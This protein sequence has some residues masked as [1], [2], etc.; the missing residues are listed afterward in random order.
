MI[1]RP[2]KYFQPNTCIDCG[3][4]ISRYS[5]RCQKCANKRP[6]KVPRDKVIEARLK[7]P[8]A[9]VKS[10][11]K[12]FNVS[13]DIISKILKEAG[14]SHREMVWRKHHPN[15]CVDCGARITAQSTRCVQCSNKFQYSQS[16]RN[17]VIKIK[18]ENPYVTLQEIGDE[19]GISR[20]RVR[21]ILSRSK[22]PTSYYKLH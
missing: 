13:P 9:M 18:K 4:E 6:I 12:M 21:Q 10:I 20:E 3:V 1:G 17:K 5:T 16:A 2:R 19:V 14:L 8:D 15:F 7:N 22:L 11:A